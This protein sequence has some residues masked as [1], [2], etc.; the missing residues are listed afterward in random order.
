MEFSARLHQETPNF[1]VI[2]GDLDSEKTQLLQEK[3]EYLQGF[4][5]KLYTLS[6]KDMTDCDVCF[7]STIRQYQ[8]QAVLVDAC[9]EAQYQRLKALAAVPYTSFQY[10]I[11]RA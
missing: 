6:G 8:P 5:V 9:T 2:T 10:I 3:A 4:G 11:V 1:A 7:M